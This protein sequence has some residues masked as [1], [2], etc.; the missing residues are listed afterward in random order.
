MKRTALIISMTLCVSLCSAYSQN[1]KEDPKQAVRLV[2]V[3]INKGRGM[4]AGWE[5]T[6]LAIEVWNKS[7]RSSVCFNVEYQSNFAGTGWTSNTFRNIKLYRGERRIIH[8]ASEVPIKRRT[9][10]G[11]NLVKE[12]HVCPF[13]NVKLSGVIFCQ[14]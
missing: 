9:T 8:I 11:Y 4:E 1:I 10:A 7:T 13:R 14:P 2:Q 12:T 6:Q 5:K 3:L